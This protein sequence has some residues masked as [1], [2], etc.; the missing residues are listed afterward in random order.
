MNPRK[1]GVKGETSEW[2][3]FNYSSYDNPLLD[4]KEIDELA[5]DI[6]PCLREQEIFGKFI[7]KETSG[8]IKTEWWRYFNPI[9]LPS[10]RVLK[11][12]QS[13][14]TAFKEK[15]SNDFSVCTTWL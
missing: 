7:D 2:E 9:E 13:W 3:S 11:K 12:V 10:E 8:I 5:N 4:P 1:G 6:S 14:D 15:E